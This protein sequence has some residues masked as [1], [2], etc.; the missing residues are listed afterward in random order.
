M[1]MELLN[2]SFLTP[3]GGLSSIIIEMREFLSM[4]MITK[5]DLVRKL[6]P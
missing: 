2:M 4:L 5:G 6:V 3:M 1:I